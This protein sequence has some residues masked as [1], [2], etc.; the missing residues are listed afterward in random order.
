MDKNIPT[1]NTE[2]LVLVP[3][4]IERVTKTHVA[5][6]NDADVVRYSEQRHK[7][8]SLVSQREYLRRLPP[9]SCIW[10]IRVKRDIG[11]DDIGTVSAH[12]D[13]D[14]NSADM[15][16]LVGDKTMWGKGYAKEAW[17]CV[18]GWLREQQIHW[19]EC[20]YME[21]NHA[22]EGLA[23]SVGMFPTG[24]RTL[25]FLADDGQRRCAF[26]YGRLLLRPTYLWG[27]DE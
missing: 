21:G 1:L 27:H 20:G 17:T 4:T 26:F 25:H 16:I 8:H 7:K 11:A 19:V 23:K 9:S 12:I 15:G 3:Y 18:M 6:L 2:R 10:L 22:M 13:A 14:N 5:W 24:H